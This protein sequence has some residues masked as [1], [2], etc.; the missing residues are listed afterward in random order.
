MMY[1][2]SRAEAV[3]V[4][5]LTFSHTVLQE[6]IDEEFCWSLKEMCNMPQSM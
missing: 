3:N 2:E 6:S 1:V 5:S 4:F